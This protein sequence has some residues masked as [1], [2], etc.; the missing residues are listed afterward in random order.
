MKSNKIGSA[1]K[2]VPREV[3][4][5]YRKTK[6]LSFSRMI[7]R[8]VAEFDLDAAIQALSSTQ[9]SIR[10]TRQEDVWRDRLMTL[11]GY[12]NTSPRRTRRGG[13]GGGGYTDYTVT[14][15]TDWSQNIPF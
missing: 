8:D 6:G 5:K 14:S 13:G 3:I 11:Q 4:K 7:P 2:D 12:Y 10:P 15:A 9:A 1:Y